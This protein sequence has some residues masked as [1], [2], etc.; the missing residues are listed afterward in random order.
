MPRE[1]WRPHLES[2]LSLSVSDLKR[3]GAIQPGRTCGGTWQWSRGG[4]PS[5][6]ISYRVAMADHT[7]TLTLTYTTT[8]RNGGK[9]N[10]SYDVTLTSEPMRFGGVRWWFR[11]PYTSRRVLKLYKFGS[12]DKFCARTAIRPLPTYA[13]QRVSGMDAIQHARW[14][15]RRKLGDPGDLRDNLN[16]PRWMRWKTFDRFAERDE[17][18][19]EREDAAFVGHFGRLMTRLAR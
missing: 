9:Q 15:L 16:K 11:C 17:H 1:G 6:S 14:R 13:S 10:H 19:G 4:E 7:G 12:V 5:G 2:A 18:L 8:D 3:A